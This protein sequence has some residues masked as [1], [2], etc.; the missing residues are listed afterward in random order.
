MS[1]IG[2]GTTKARGASTAGLRASRFNAPA[3][4]LPAS[5]RRAGPAAA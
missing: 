4:R 5:T 1:P 3:V 2:L